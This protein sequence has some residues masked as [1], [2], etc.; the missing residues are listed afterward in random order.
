MSE[1]KTL[2][3]GEKRDITHKQM[4]VKSYTLVRNNSNQRQWNNIFKALKDRRRG[5]QTNKHVQDKW[6][7]E[8]KAKKG[9]F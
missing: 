6:A 3:R 9:T 8:L 5:D 4:K 2:S 7:S 1:K